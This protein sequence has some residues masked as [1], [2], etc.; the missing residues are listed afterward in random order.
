MNEAKGKTVENELKD[1]GAEALFIEA[2]VTNEDQV[3]HVFQTA[4]S[5]FVKWMFFSIMLESVRRNQRKK[6]HLMSG[7][8]RLVLT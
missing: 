5:T 8:K 2:D 1:K 7:E 4:V 6:L 3:N